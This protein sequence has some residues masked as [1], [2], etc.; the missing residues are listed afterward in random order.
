MASDYITVRPVLAEPEL[1]TQPESAHPPGNGHTSQL[2]GDH[3]SHSE[4]PPSHVCP[5]L[6]QDCAHC[7]KACNA[8]H[9]RAHVGYAE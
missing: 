3:A 5:Y 8:C 1:E 4:M 7:Q 6:R 9:A 2:V